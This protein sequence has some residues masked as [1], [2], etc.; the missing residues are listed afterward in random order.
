MARYIQAP[1]GR[2]VRQGQLKTGEFGV[3]V[4]VPDG[5]SGSPPV[6]LSPQ[7][8]REATPPV[9]RQPVAGNHTNE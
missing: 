8:I 6:H 1:L 7:A 9:T 5:R 2:N 3:R 4:Q